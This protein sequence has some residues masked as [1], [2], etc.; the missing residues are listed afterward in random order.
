MPYLCIHHANKSNVSKS[1][2]IYLFNLLRI[3]LALFSFL[4][5]HAVAVTI[6]WYER[7][8]NP[9]SSGFAFVAS[10]KV[11]QL[12]GTFAEFLWKE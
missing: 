8:G 2:Y 5:I 10:G 3:E 11:L 7:V 6:S 4:V 12:S 1:N 9:F